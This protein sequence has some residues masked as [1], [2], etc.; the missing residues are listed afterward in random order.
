MHV[1]ISLQIWKLVSAHVN[2]LRE[3]ASLIEEEIRKKIQYKET[4]L[5]DKYNQTSHS[6]KLF[7][8]IYG[9]KILICSYTRPY[10]RSRIS[11][12]RVRN[13]VFS[14]FTG[15]ST[16]PSTYIGMLTSE[17]NILDGL[18]F[19]YDIW[20]LTPFSRKFHSV[21][22]VEETG[23]PRENHRP[24]GSHWQT[25]S[26]E[27]WKLTYSIFWTNTPYMLISKAITLY[28]CNKKSSNKI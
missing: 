10:W 9:S 13:P 23:V 17:E 8:W 7:S 25:L 22:L 19:V 12:V 24:V 11:S 6:V 4:K 16:T 1:T 15:I 5:Y 14:R 18:W 27:Y 28:K 3:Y 20:C 26:R 2:E 21:L